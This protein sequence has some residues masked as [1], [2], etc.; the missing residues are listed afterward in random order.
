MTTCAGCNCH[1]DTNLDI[2]LQERVT[3][4]GAVL[5]THNYYETRDFCSAGCLQDYHEVVSQGRERRSHG[6]VTV[7][8]P[9][10]QLYR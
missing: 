5:G 9:N 6:V 10:W 3:L 4:P 1:L 8:P 7:N 2:I